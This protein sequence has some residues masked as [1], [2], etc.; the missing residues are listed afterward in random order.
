MANEH[1]LISSYFLSGVVCLAIGVAAWLW[2]RRPFGAVADALPGRHGPTFL[3]RAFPV[4]MILP[5]LAA[6]F[7][8]SY[9]GRGCTAGRSYQ[10]IVTDRTYIMAKNREQVTG[11]LADTYIAV[12]I[13]G[14]VVLLLLV[15]ARRA[16]VGPGRSGEDVP[17][18]GPAPKP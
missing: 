7:Y 3:K 2:L 1:Y 6:F 16:V 18:Q 15:A 4:S 12:I 13:W 17:A 9:Y 5:A 8:V 11:A 10:S 14:F